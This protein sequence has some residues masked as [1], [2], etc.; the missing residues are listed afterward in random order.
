[1]IYTTQIR[2]KKAARGL[3]SDLQ[4]LGRKIAERLEPRMAA[5]LEEGEKMPDVAHLLHV[6]GRMLVLESEGVEAASEDRSREGWEVSQ[7]RDALRHKAE[8]ELRSRVVWVRAQMRSGYGPEEA[9]KM[10]RHKGRTPR[11]REDLKQMAENMVDFLPRVTPPEPKPGSRL[12]PVQ[13]AEY[14]RPALADFERE[15]GELE[16]HSGDQADL[17]D[18]RNAALAT[19]DLNYS[20]IVRLT[21]LFFELSGLDSL[22]KHLRYHPGRP[23]GRPSEQVP[24]TAVQ[25]DGA[26][27]GRRGAGP[28]RVA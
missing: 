3:A 18:Q 15:L 11:A 4:Q 14:L 7:T 9:N 19:F 6:L 26:K 17:V 8:P 10:L 27:K 5:V 25:R 13:W 21:E 2:R 23:T 16:A 1:M 12:N 20:R 24:A 22:I 28:P